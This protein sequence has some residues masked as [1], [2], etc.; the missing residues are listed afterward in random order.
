[1]KSKPKLIYFHSRKCIW[2]CRLQ[3][4]WP[5]CLGPNVLSSC[6]DKHAV[7]LWSRSPS[8]TSLRFLSEAGY[9]DVRWT[10][11]SLRG[12][13][14][15]VSPGRH[16][17]V[18]WSTTGCWQE[19]VLICCVDACQVLSMFLSPLIVLHMFSRVLLGYM[20]LR[21]SRTALSVFSRISNR[22]QLS[23]VEL[24][25]YVAETIIRHSHDF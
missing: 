10:H 21:Q 9:R 19:S 18:T 3:T 25:F 14:A 2:K 24:C 13:D 1:M 4:C 7:R 12:C 11:S 22:I 6:S 8:R 17:L 15:H 5:S 23:Y 16:V 20:T